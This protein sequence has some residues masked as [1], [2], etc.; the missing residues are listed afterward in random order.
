MR[1][2]Y[3][4]L[5]LKTLSCDGWINGN[6]DAFYYSEADPNHHFS[7]RESPNSL[8]TLPQWIHCQ[9]AAQNYIQFLTESGATSV[10]QNPMPQFNID[11]SPSSGLRTISIDMA[12]NKAEC[13]KSSHELATLS[14]LTGLEKQMP[15]Q[16]MQNVIEDYNDVAPSL[17]A[18]IPSNASSQNYLSADR[19]RRLKITERLEAF[20]DFFPHPKSG[21]KPAILDDVVDYI[22]YLQFQIKELSQSRLGGESSGTPFIFLEG[23][24]HYLVEDEVLSEPL[25]E[26]VGKLLEVNPFAATQLFESKGILMMPMTLAEGLC[27]ES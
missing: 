6:G 13:V 2:C 18:K 10:S 14:N 7:S 19:R 12:S 8:I 3:N 5:P 9:K 24:G 21:G 20:Q 27:P 25:E 4:A 26:L 16:S 15:F 1:D 11:A 22:K 23:Y 17:A